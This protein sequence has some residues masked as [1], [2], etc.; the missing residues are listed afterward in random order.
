[1][2]FRTALPVLFATA[3]ALGCQAPSVHVQAP[4]CDCSCQFRATAPQVGK[5]CYVSDDVLI[6]PLVRRTL[7]LEPAYPTEDPRCEKQADGTL[8]CEVGGPGGG[9]P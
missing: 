2:L 7:D 6:C 5:G 4:P 9:T 1:M 3:L 8:R